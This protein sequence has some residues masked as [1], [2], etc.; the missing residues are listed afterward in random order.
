MVG[1]DTIRIYVAGP[2]TGGDTDSNVE[3]AM[4]V[5]SKLIKRGYTPF[6]PHL[7]HY[8]HLLWP[9]SYETWME[10][11]VSWL[12]KCDAVLRI[13]GDS[14]GAERE[15]AIAKDIGIPVF[16]TI[17]ELVEFYEEDELYVG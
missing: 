11:G 17:S 9:G 13:P 1:E 16:Y 14:P 15:V 2:Y 7:Y 4:N 3:I 5:G 8:I 6:V 12:K 10:Q